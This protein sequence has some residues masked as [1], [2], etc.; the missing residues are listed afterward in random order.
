LSSCVRPPHWP[1]ARP[2][3]RTSPS[4]PPAP[5]SLPLH[6][7]HPSSQRHGER[8]TPARIPSSLSHAPGLHPT[9]NDC[10]STLC[11]DSRTT[12]TLR[13][14]SPSVARTHFVSNEPPI[15]PTSTHRRT[16]STCRRNAA[17]TVRPRTVDIA[18]AGICPPSIR[19]ATTA[20]RHSVER[21]TCRVHGYGCSCAAVRAT[22]SASSNA[23]T[24]TTHDDHHH[25]T[26]T[27]SEN[28]RRRADARGPG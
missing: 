25:L 12:C 9:R 23:T 15:P 16:G 26:T 19:S 4:A 3:C 7:Q 5:T 8:K 21:R 18:A 6:G 27:I 13:L 28:W 1:P 17:G 2:S 22:T 11:R 20:S 14:S 10:I 24:H